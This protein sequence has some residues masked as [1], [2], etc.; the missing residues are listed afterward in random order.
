[1]YGAISQVARSGL[2]LAILFMLVGVS[3]GLSAAPPDWPE[4]DQ[5]PPD[6]AF[7]YG[8]DKAHWQTRA[9]VAERYGSDNLAYVEIVNAD[10][11]PIKRQLGF[12]LKE[13][14][15]KAEFC[16]TRNG[17]AYLGPVAD[18]E[19]FCRNL[20]FAE[21]LERDEVSKFVKVR[22]D[23]DK[24]FAK[25]GGVRID[26]V[27][28]EELSAVDFEDRDDPSRNFALSLEDAAQVK[29]R[30]W[31]L[32]NSN[33]RYECAAVLNFD[34]FC[35]RL[36]FAEILE[37]DTAT[38]SLKL[39][40]RIDRL[41]GDAVLKRLRSTEGLPAWEK[42]R[43]GLVKKDAPSQNRPASSVADRITLDRKLPG[44]SDP[45]YHK[46]LC[47]LMVDET[48][49]MLNDKAIDA[50]LAVN[51]QD[52]SDKA[53]RKQIAV[54]FRTLALKEGHPDGAQKA[55]RGLV[56]YGGKYSV[57]I[58]I[59]VLEQEHFKAPQEL[60]DGLAAFP[61][62][63]GAEALAGRL[64]DFFNHA[65]A[66]TALRQMGPVAEDSLLKAAPS[67]NPDISLA[68][69]RLLGDIGTQKSLALLSKATQSSNPDVAQAAKDS[70]KAI[71]ARTR[72]VSQKR[73][74]PSREAVNSP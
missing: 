52:I 49:W 58:L 3:C 16:L 23:R 20:D 54:N 57:P 13:A 47:D 72:Q 41:T 32:H 67:D 5:P 70:I 28:Q 18:F 46:Q 10:E 45:E 71:R 61:S 68:A 14:A 21:I 63:N 17:H 74:A 40:A 73:P 4:F 59:E 37:K 27:N 6:V 38:R 33:G 7:I 12:V 15:P 66:V 31:E 53:V 43:L 22:I 65:A 36:T 56:L 11:L 35:D 25:A 19:L 2:R 39:R 42:E 51:P 55:V 1:M 9:E 26:V 29:D 48:N 69:V 50:L 8:P 60:F 30:R 34:S 64:G 44:P 24:Y 62:A